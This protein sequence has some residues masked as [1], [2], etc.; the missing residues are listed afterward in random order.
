MKPYLIMYTSP[1]L[2]SPFSPPLPLPRPPLSKSCSVLHQTPLSIHPCPCGEWGKHTLTYLY[3]AA[4]KMWQHTSVNAFHWSLEH[5]TPFTPHFSPVIMLFNVFR[6][7]RTAVWHLG[8]AISEDS[9]FCPLTR[10]I[11][12]VMLCDHR[13]SISWYVWEHRESDVGALMLGGPVIFH[14][15]VLCEIEH[16][17][18]SGLI[19]FCLWQDEHAVWAH[20]DTKSHMHAS[21]EISNSGNEHK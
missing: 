3:F 8:M 4:T 21:R 14:C 17:G 18:F 1:F 6:E 13:E 9:R 10:S 20:A 5:T 16:D 2:F 11:T 19:V 7:D 12:N 15:N